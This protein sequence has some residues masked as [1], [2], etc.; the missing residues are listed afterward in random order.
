M[1]VE[2]RDGD[3]LPS[4]LLTCGCLVPLSPGLWEEAAIPP[5]R[6]KRRCCLNTWGWRD[7]RESVT[8]STDATAVLWALPHPQGCCSAGPGLHL[9]VLTST[10]P[11][12]LPPQA[13]G[14]PTSGLSTGAIVGI[15][16]VTFVLLLVA[17]D[18]TC[19][20]LNKCGLLMCIA[21]NLCGKAGPG[22]KGKDMEEGKAAFS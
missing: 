2:S 5:S 14:S 21:V 15:L 8:L 11:L 13:N 20:F 10:I 6:R 1:W 18:V 22:A 12:S 3:T 7:P 4:L 9:S 19:Y 17:V 16:V